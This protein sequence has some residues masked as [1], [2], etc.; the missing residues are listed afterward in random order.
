MGGVLAEKLRH[1]GIDV[2]LVTPAGY[3]SAWTQHT[4]EQMRI[5]ARMIE[6]GVRIE[7]GAVLESIGDGSAVLACAYTGRTHEV[8]AAGAVMVTS[9]EPADSLYHELC[10]KIDVVRI[11]DCLAPGTIA[12]AVYSGHRYAREMDAEP[13]GDVAFRREH[14]LAPP[15]TA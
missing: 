4:D 7:V 6:A 10:E 13:G 12:T 2:L 8:E 14:A 11:G 3:V 1:D 15:D 5:Q 9:R